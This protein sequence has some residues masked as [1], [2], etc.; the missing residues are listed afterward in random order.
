MYVTY[1]VLRDVEHASERGVCGCALQLSYGAGYHAALTIRL[2]TLVK[3]YANLN[4]HA[5][6]SMPMRRPAEIMFVVRKMNVKT[7]KER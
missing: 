2:Q 3:C 6:S 4:G 5:R 7:P 1:I